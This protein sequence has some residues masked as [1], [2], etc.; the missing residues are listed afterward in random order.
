MAKS[1]VTLA[2]L[3]LSGCVIKEIYLERRLG[4]AYLAS[5]FAQVLRQARQFAYYGAS[6]A[7][8]WFLLCQTNTHAHLR[9]DYLSYTG[10]VASERTG[11]FNGR[12]SVL[13]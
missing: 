9:K 13:M 4:F 12:M 5:A 3:E 8:G 2:S 1:E 10:A 7:A 6:T 11:V